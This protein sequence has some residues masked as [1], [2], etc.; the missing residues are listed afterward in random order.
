MNK[1][2]AFS[3]ISI[4]IILSGCTPELELP[5]VTAG[6][7]NFS[8]SVAIGGNYLAGYQDGALYKK[9][10]SLSIPALLA[11]QFEFA[12]GGTFSQALMPDDNGLG[13]S[14]K[15]WEGWYVTPS[16]LGDKTNCQGVTS[17]SPLK[18]FIAPSAAVPYLTGVAGNSI[19]N[20]AIPYAT[21]PDYFDPNFGISTNPG[22]LNP[23]YARVASDPGA[24]TLF[25]DVRHQNAT[26]VTAWLGME[27]IYNYAARGG[28]GA[29]IPS[30][31]S[32][33]SYLD[34]ILGGLTAN[35]AKG[36]IANIP[37]F[38][39]YPY[40][41]LVAWDNAVLVRQ[42]QVDSLNDIYTTSG[43][44]HMHFAL[45]RNGF[46]INDAAAPG[47]VRQTHAG[48]Y[49][50][51][52]VPI[53]SMKCYKY[54]LFFETLN[55]RYVLDSSEVYEI[56]NAISSY[57]AVIAAKASQY[58]LALA[59]MHSYMSKV[60]SGIKW[61]GADMNLQ[62]VSGGFLSLDGYHPNQKGYSLIANEFIKAVNSKY[63]STVP[64]VYCT[65]CDGVKFP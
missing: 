34:T 10:Q 24:S 62:F 20:W 44:S 18:N 9:G 41:T 63:G 65:E 55:D 38:R 16:H 11:E 64:E 12:G 47:G 48:E 57:N 5:D 23:Y 45:G 22:N 61:N 37:D 58:G 4:C 26:F 39:N 49:I 42:S 56:D 2:I 46:V 17:L 14:S 15:I 19:Q 27:D 21:I 53:D 25:E 35:G 13:L 33:S 28:T 43:L 29:G 30:A 36:V 52:S 40:Y 8:K 59:D 32:F 51:L 54:G 7:A 3:F 50:T 1:L 6:S 60:F 31:A